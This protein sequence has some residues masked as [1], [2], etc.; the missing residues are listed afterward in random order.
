MT[1]FEARQGVIYEHKLNHLMLLFVR[2]SQAVSRQLTSLRS[3]QVV[4]PQLRRSSQVQGQAQTCYDT[5]R[6]KQTYSI[7]QTNRD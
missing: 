3:N 7:G 6:D 5:A 4:S 2:S 1:I